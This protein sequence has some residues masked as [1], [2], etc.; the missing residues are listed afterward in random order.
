[1]KIPISGFIINLFLIL[2]L[3]PAMAQTDTIPERMPPSRGF[4][5]GVNLS[6]PLMTYIE[7]SRFGVEAMADFNLGYEYFA[8]AEAGYSFRELERPSYQLKENGM[9]IRLG[10]DKNYYKHF[11]DVIALG[12]RLGFSSYNRS[13]PSIT[14]HDNYWGGFTGSLPEETFYKQW[15]EVV[16]VLKTELFSNFFLGW[17][18]RGKLLL[19]GKEDRN[20]NDRYIPGFGS[21][22]VNSTASFDFYIYYRFPLK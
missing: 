5:I 20:M 14:V 19:F 7:P 11:D 17:N 1:L 2:Y 4:R 16:I 18:L 10:A 22:D 9:F 3:V 21:S 8:V 6:R 15:A 13:A 12:G